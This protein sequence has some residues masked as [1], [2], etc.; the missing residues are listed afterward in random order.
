MMKRF[1]VLAFLL[2][3]CT[4]MQEPATPPANLEEAYMEA[5]GV[6]ISALSSMVSFKKDCEERPPELRADCWP[7]V[8]RIRGIAKHG[9]AYRQAMDVAYKSG[10]EGEFNAS[11]TGLKAV[12]TA[13]IA[14]VS[15]QAQTEPVK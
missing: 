13:I 1:V 15:R 6:Y 10:N 2:A 8:E 5:Q 14:E 11:L 7:T 9:I 4:S 12:R 3:G